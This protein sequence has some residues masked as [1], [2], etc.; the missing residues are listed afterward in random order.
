MRS[1]RI[2]LIGLVLA[3]APG[4]ATAQHAPPAYDSL[5][6]DWGAQQDEVRACVAAGRCVPAVGVIVKIRQLTPGHSLDVGLE[7]EG[8]REVYRI[9]WAASD[10]RR[11]DYIADAKTGAI[12]RAEGR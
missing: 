5:G 12:L 7:P 8:G 11:I 2:L 1:L 4:L 3:A 10:G 6:A 9:R